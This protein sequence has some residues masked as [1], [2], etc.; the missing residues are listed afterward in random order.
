MN[1][2]GFLVAIV[3]TLYL[4]GCAFVAVDYFKYWRHGVT[5]PNTSFDEVRAC[6]AVCGIGAA[7]AVYYCI[8][9]HGQGWIPIEGY[10]AILVGYMI[11]YNNWRASTLKRRGV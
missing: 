2:L 6:K 8:T 10:V 9:E 7:L 5:G 4:T 3:R 1:W 11:L